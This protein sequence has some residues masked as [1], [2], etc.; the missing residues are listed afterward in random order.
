MA[1]QL[2]EQGHHTL[3]HPMLASCGTDAAGRE[4][5]RIDW[6]QVRV[7]MRTDADDRPTGAAK[8]IMAAYA[9]GYIDGARGDKTRVP[10]GA[11]HPVV[12]TLP[13]LA[14]AI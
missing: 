3:P 6:E 4:C 1:E 5:V 9:Q 8:V 2:S 13:M 7:A 14:L 11:P 12:A 10:P